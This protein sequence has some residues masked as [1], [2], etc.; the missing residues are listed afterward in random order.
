MIN[1]S[2]LG[3]AVIAT[4]TLCQGQ[5][6]VDFQPNTFSIDYE[7]QDANS[8]NPIF[9]ATL[10]LYGYNATA[11]STS[12]S[13]NATTQGLYLGLGYNTDVMDNADFTMCLVNLTANA[14]FLCQDGHFGPTGLPFSINETQNVGNVTTLAANVSNGTFIVRFTRPFSTSEGLTGT[15]ANLSL[16][17]LPFIWAY[18]PV[19]NSQPSYHTQGQ[20]GS[21]TLD[22]RTD[23]MIN[24]ANEAVANNTIP[25]S[26]GGTPTTPVPS[27]GFVLKAAGLLV[28]MLAGVML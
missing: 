13:T 10:T 6:H 16:A 11:Q 22:L 4:L 28:S 27:T 5:R 19:N 17:Q 24:A 2:R 18:G 26:S 14:T 25:P 1:L 9:N 23:E 12:N 3:F 20:K 7:V 8:S 15:D 21:V